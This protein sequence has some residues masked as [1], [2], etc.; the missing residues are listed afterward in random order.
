MVHLETIVTLGCFSAVS[1]S[2][3]L[4]NK[5]ALKAFP[6]PSTLSVLYYACGASNRAVTRVRPHTPPHAASPRSTCFVPRARWHR[7]FVASAAFVLLL[8]VFGCADPDAFQWATVRAFSVYVRV[9][10]PR[11]L[12]DTHLHCV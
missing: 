1:S 11:T 10:A 9:C 2:L 5:L 4:V 7:Q 12:K 8:K 3:L 6:M